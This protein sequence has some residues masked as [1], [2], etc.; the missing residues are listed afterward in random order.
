MYPLSPEERL[1]STILN[2]GVKLDTTDHAYLKRL[3]KRILNTLTDQEQTILRLRFGLAGSGQTYTLQAIAAEF[4]LTR[5]R[6]RQ[7]KYQA[8]TKIRESFRM[9]LVGAALDLSRIR[10][11]ARN[12]SGSPRTSG[13]RPTRQS[14]RDHELE[15]KVLVPQCEVHRGSTMTVTAR[16]QRSTPI[17]VP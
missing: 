12:L 7:R 8:L 4:G 6:M 16:A 15:G 9:D 17:F 2:T 5:E 14:V 10:P 11:G 1:L 13:A 3:L